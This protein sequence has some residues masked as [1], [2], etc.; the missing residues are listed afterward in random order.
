MEER[1]TP[2]LHSKLC[3][4][5]AQLTKVIYHLNTRNED[6]E[7]R[8]QALQEDYEAEIESLLADASAKIA[9]ASE[10]GGGKQAVAA[11]AEKAAALERSFAEEKKQSLEQLESY[12]AKL[13]VCPRA[14]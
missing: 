8:L 4:K 13:K 3:K 12:K 7:G 6:S 5:V 9:A 14:R 11:I 1:L 10:A 2:E